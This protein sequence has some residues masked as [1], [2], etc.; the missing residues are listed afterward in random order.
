MS[1]YEQTVLN[2]RKQFLKLNKSQERELLNLYKELAK[3]LQSDIATCRTTSQETYLNNLHQIVEMNIKD[4]SGELEKKIKAN[5]ETASQI[6]S[7]TELAYYQVLTDDVSLSAAF[8]GMVI[9]TSHETVKKLIQGQFYKDKTSLD[10]RLWNITDKS[11]KD[12]DTLIKVNVLRGA[13]AKELAKQVE[14]Y[15]NPLKKLELKND[16]VGFNKNVSYQATRLARTSITHSFRETQIQQAMNN[17]FNQGMKWEL[18]PSHGIRMHGKTDICDDYAT[19]NNYELGT[20]VFPVDKMPIGHPQCLCITYQVNTNTRSAMEELKAWTN[21]EPNEKL[22][23]WY[24]GVEW[25]DKE[26]AKSS[27]EQVKANGKD[28]TIQVKIPKLIDKKIDTNTTKSGMI[29]ESKLYRKSK[30]GKIKPMPKKQLR[31]IVKGFSRNGGII[32]INKETDAY[33]KSK[34]AEAITYNE[35]TILLRQN[36][37]RAAVFEELI[38]ATQYKDGM[39]DGSLESRLICEIEAQKKLIKYS[40]AYKLTGIEIKQTKSA[41][42]SYKKQLKEYYKKGGM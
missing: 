32:Q 15:V 1:T 41:L 11:V 13:N 16:E 29:K 35:S 36:T 26:E 20:G 4:L 21:G 42:E 8:K 5:I 40:N 33:L 9:N 39:N 30:M 18:S 3:Q 7:T 22:D 28:R 38:H 25:T 14:K 34:A 6:A 23:K 31:K 37:G 12:I 24:E 10:Q 19:Q 2:A 17:P 27:K